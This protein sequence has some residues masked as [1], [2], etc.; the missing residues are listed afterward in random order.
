MY[1]EL[2]GKRIR[3][4]KI[5]KYPR[6]NIGRYSRIYLPYCHQIIGVFVKNDIRKKVPTLFFN[7]QNTILTDNKCFTTA[8]KILPKKIKNTIVRKCV[9]ICCDHLE[10]DPTITNFRMTYY[11]YKILKK[12]K[13][14]YTP[15]N[16]IILKIIHDGNTFKFITPNGIGIINNYKVNLK[17]FKKNKI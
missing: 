15:I 8:M 17:L 6:L 14:I 11:R 13:K 7:C 3:V 5:I 1:E 16:V 12:Y 4:L 2:I 9:N 10:D